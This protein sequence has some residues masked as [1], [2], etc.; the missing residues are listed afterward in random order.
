MREESASSDCNEETYLTPN[1]LKPDLPDE[2]KIQ[3]EPEDPEIRLEFYIK[4]LQACSSLGTL[5]GETSSY[6]K[7]GYEQ[8]VILG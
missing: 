2:T 1:S 3:V 8:Q 7:A 4:L 6:R 5:R